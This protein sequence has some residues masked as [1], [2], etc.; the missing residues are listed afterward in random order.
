VPL[1]CRITCNALC[2]SMCVK[3]G[4][5]DL[6]LVEAIKLLLALQTEFGNVAS[7]PP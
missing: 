3:S 4:P 2:T 1:V 5:V 6:A 7:F